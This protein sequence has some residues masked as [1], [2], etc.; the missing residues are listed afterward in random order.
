MSG[1][2]PSSRVTAFLWERLSAILDSP[3][4]RDGSIALVRRH[5]LILA[6]EGGAVPS[7]GGRP[8]QLLRLLG[9]SH[10][11]SSV[12]SRLGDGSA[13]CERTPTFTGVS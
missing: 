9:S 5:S 3:L 1:R 8:P 10:L 11:A 6:T 12:S 2:D 7:R 4:V 13:E